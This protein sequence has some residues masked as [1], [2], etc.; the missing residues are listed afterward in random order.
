M[1]ARHRQFRW[2][3]E[4]PVQ[5]MDLLERGVTKDQRLALAVPG[6]DAVSS[7]PAN[8]GLSRCGLEDGSHL[9]DLASVGDDQRFALEGHQVVCSGGILPVPF[10]GGGEN[11]GWSVCGSLRDD[12]RLCRRTTAK[13]YRGDPEKSCNPHLLSIPC[14]CS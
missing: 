9:S 2:L 3:P 13:E 5:G 14:F 12:G 1:E 7:E 4:Q 11:R 8:S 10:R 6:E